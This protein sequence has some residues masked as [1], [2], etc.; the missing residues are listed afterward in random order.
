MNDSGQGSSGT[1]L[2]AE[3]AV[4]P[5]DLSASSSVSPV[6]SAAANRGPE[7]CLPINKTFFRSALGETV[8]MLSLPIY[9]DAL[10]FE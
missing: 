3:I 2:T 8:A 4:L 6:Y 10:Q 5:G 9:P 7:T 1:S